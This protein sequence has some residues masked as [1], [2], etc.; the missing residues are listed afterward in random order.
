M[1]A[2]STLPEYDHAARQYVRA[3][4]CD[5]NGHAAITPDKVVSRPTGNGAAAMHIHGVIDDLAHAFRVVVFQDRTQHS[6]L[7]TDA[8]RAGSHAAGSIHAVGQTGNTRQRFL[9]AFELAD[10]NLELFANA[11]VGARH[12][13]GKF[14]HTGAQRRQGDCPPDR[15]AL[16][17]H[18]PA[19]ANKL[20]AADYPL[21]GH[22]DILTAVGSVLKCS[23]RLVAVADR[24][25][26]CVGGDEGTGN[27]EIFFVTQETF[28]IERFERQAQQC[29]YRA[30]RDV[31]LFPVDA[32]AE[33][34][35]ALIDTLTEVAMVRHC[36][37]V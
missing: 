16:H 8:Q 36:T 27:A 10:R 3:L 37:G 11:G 1:A 20:L 22:K 12:A 6:R 24:Y 13:A 15:Q 7:L 28:R 14:A 23:A 26:R 31:T 21:H 4:D 19:L 33:D 5:R 30:Q 2:Y 34:L 25:A 17:E 32:E 29:R 35:F 9:D 18:A